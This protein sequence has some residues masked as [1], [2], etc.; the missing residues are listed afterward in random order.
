[1]QPWLRAWRLHQP[2]VTNEIK[3]RGLAT[4]FKL[5]IE[6]QT[7]STCGT[8]GKK[9]EVDAGAAVLSSPSHP[10]RLNVDLPEVAA[11]TLAGVPN[12]KACVLSLLGVRTSNDSALGD[13]T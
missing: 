8:A 7:N 2:D 4:P 1:M 5:I 12:L 6:Q 9:G 10:E 11:I 13:A 3:T